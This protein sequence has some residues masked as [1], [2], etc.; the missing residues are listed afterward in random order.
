MPKTILPEELESSIRVIEA[1]MREPMDLDGARPAD[2]LKRKRKKAARQRRRKSL[3]GERV[4]TRRRQADEVQQF[5]SAQFI[6]DSDDDEAADAEFF[7]REAANRD[8]SRQNIS[9]GLAP[10]SSRGPKQDNFSAAAL[11]DNSDGVDGD[12]ERQ[13]GRT[14]RLPSEPHQ[15]VTGLGDEERD[16]ADTLRTVRPVPRKRQKRNVPSTASDDLSDARSS[17][18]PIGSPVD[19]LAGSR[20]ARKRVIALSSDED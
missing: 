14:S 3:D 4:P 12:A 6:Y 11:G 8:R 17:R 20:R 7:A 19:E 15:E 18:S 1:F 9:N 5:K 13:S 2:L 16:F 10:P